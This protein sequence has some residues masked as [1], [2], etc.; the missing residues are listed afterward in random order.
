MSAWSDPRRC[1]CREV[2]VGKRGVY[3]EERMDRK[4]IKPDALVGL[5]LTA[6]E[7]K[8]LLTAVASLDPGYAKVVQET[9]AAQPVKLTLDQWEDLG[10]YVAREANH[11]KDRK[12]Q[13]KLDALFTKVQRLL[14]S[15]AAEEDLQAVKIGEEKE[16]SEL[17]DQAVQIAAWAVETLGLAD[18][19]GIKDEPLPNFFLAPAQ[20]EVL[21]LV[22]GMAAAIRAKLARDEWNVTPSE[23]VGMVLALAEDLVGS[24]GQK[25]LALLVVLSHL[26]ERLQEGISGPTTTPRPKEKK[27]RKKPGG[28]VASVVVFQFK[29]TLKGVKPPIWRRIQVKDCTLDKLHEHIQTAMGWTN[30][31]LHQFQISGVTYGDPALLSEG[32]E[33]DLEVRDS[34]GI[35][36]SDL[37][38]KDRK[39]FRFE[40]RYDFGDCWDHEILFEGCPAAAK[41]T[42]YPLCLEGERACPPDDVGGVHG[43]A[44]Y[45]EAMSD[46]AHP[47]HKELMGWGGPFDPERFDAE[48]A[49]KAMRKGLPKGEQ[50]F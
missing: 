4:H 41:G 23:A 45:R 19:L 50:W 12:L 37:V 10:G 39:R 40:Y 42:R 17:A 27:S 11:T 48:D 34:R 13:A 38:P 26:M 5:K 3:K 22:P 20:R 35:T 7:R 9:P 28:K 25:R 1:Q 46:P 44:L 29:I 36:I 24:Q 2:D 43:Y 30:S 33:D 14:G 31:H 15:H 21:I 8:L 47:Q 32:F 16:V 6:A 18:R 49:T